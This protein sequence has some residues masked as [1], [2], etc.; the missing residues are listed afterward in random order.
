MKTQTTKSKPTFLQ[1]LGWVVMTFLALMLFLIASRY[2]TF[3]PDVFFPEQKLVYMAHTAMIVLH[4]AGAMLAILIGPFQFL[5]G[6]RKGR[7]LKLHRWLGR[8]YLISVLV[9]GLAGLYMATLAYG[10]VVAQLG[11]AVLGILWLFSGLMAYVHIRNKRLELHRAWM[12]RN[13]ALTFAGVT[14][15]LWLPLLSGLGMDFLPAYLIVAW[16]SWMPNLII[17][18]GMVRRRRQSQQRSVRLDATPAT[19]TR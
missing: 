9:G 7:L 16:L 10:G 4:V 1:R 19:E 6:I 15:R 17:A 14:L 12:T 5:E 18:E 2:L 8:V 3:N 13:Y 11:F